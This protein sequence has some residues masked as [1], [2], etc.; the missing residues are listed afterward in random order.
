MVDASATTKKQASA[1]ITQILCII[2]AVIAT[3]GWYLYHSESTRNTEQASAIQNLEQD[4]A[5]LRDELNEERE[6]LRQT[7]SS[8]TAESEALAGLQQSLAMEK[9][10]SEQ[11]QAELQKSRQER[12]RLETELQ[13][14]V[15]RMAAESAELEQELQRQL[16][17]QESLNEK[18]NAANT[19]K[20]QLSSHL[21]QAQNRRQ[22][23]LDQI[24]TVNNDIEAR[25]GALATANHGIQQLNRQLDQAKQE[26]DQLEYRVEELSEQQKQE[27]AHFEAL[28][29]SLERDLNESRVE[30]TQLKNRMTV[31]N[32]TSEVLF[33]SGSADITT[34]GRKVLDLIAASLNAYPNR[35]ISIE[36]HTDDV[37]IGKNLAYVS[38]WDL[39]T[40]RA[41]AAVDRLQ[42]HNGVAPGR[43]RAVGHGEFKPVASNE[44]TRGRQLNRRIEIH[45]L[46]EPAQ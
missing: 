37:P 42:Q 18:I 32:L 14:E 7:Q 11:L 43:L 33:D 20:E 27:A 17:L 22:Q 26:K 36:G 30:I 28:R 5:A 39:S 46:A 44:T 34:R 19:D 13:Q 15:S 12:Q 23:L 16:T 35:E 29:Q 4:Q 8:L 41:L 10:A 6:S 31:I 25:E 2:L 1:T 21:Q 40:T 38:N 45:L 24:A 9:E 3:I